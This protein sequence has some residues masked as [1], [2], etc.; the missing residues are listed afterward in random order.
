LG[1]V[2]ED[3]AFIKQ[4][5]YKTLEDEGASRSTIRTIKEADNKALENWKKSVIQKFIDTCPPPFR[6]IIRFSTWDEAMEILTEYYRQR[7]ER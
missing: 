2:V 3:V 1:G 5:K 4:L 6:T 7:G